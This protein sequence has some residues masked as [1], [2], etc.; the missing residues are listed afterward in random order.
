MTH[1]IISFDTF[2]Y[3]KD[4][5]KSGFTEAQI[6]TQVKYAK[7]QVEL[8][9]EQADNTNNLINNNLATKKDLKEIKQELQQEIKDVKQELKFKIEKMNHKTITTLSG[10]LGGMIITGTTI[11]GFLIRN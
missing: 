8:V 11:L 1:A 6:E 4:L 10:I 7:V 3:A 2:Q 5:Q 9:K